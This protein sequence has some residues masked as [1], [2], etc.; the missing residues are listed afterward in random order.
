LACR[1]ISWHADEILNNFLAC[2]PIS[3]HADESLKTISWRADE[4]LNEAGKNHWH[5]EVKLSA[6]RRSQPQPT[7]SF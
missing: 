5:T 3:W 6:Q 7:L 1:P 2:R 4:F